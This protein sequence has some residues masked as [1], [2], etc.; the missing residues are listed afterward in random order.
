M[1]ELEGR[2]RAQTEQ[3]VQGAGEA[4]G[5][6]LGPGQLSAL[7]PTGSWQHSGC[8]GGWGPCKV[9]T[10][11]LGWKRGQDNSRTVDGLFLT[12]QTAGLGGCSQGR[13]TKSLNEFCP[14]N[15]NS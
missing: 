5:G 13:S 1:Q 9:R 14:Q 2:A 7:A 4:A 8:P 11:S 6:S 10:G 15:A 3:Q 12:L